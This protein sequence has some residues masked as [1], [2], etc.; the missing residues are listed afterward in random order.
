[1]GQCVSHGVEGDR[2][3]LHI[4]TNRVSSGMSIGVVPPQLGY[5]GLQ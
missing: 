1:M 5:T 2:H 4:H 3:T